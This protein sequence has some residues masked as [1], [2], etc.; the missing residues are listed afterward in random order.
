MGRPQKAPVD[1]GVLAPRSAVGSRH[2]SLESV[3]SHSEQWEGRQCRKGM[4]KVLGHQGW[5]GSCGDFLSRDGRRDPVEEDREFW[6]KTQGL[7][8][9]G[10]SLEDWGV[11][12]G[13]QSGRALLWG[14]QGITF[15]L[16]K[17]CRLRSNGGEKGLKSQARMGSGWNLS[18]RPLTR[19]PSWRGELGMG[20]GDHGS[21][22]LSLGQPSPA[23]PHFLI[24]R[25]GC[26]LAGLS[27]S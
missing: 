6:G 23:E 5:S 3:G 22:P 8:A 4:M 12:A 10:W 24:S 14:G 20:F 15:G 16:Q 26:S 7:P 21:S 13:R 25:V 11:W 2:L 27:G 9:I 17:C 1:R 18:A 19:E